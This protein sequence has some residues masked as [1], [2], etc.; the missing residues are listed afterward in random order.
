MQHPIRH[1]VMP[2]EVMLVRLQEQLFQN[3]RLKRILRHRCHRQQVQRVTP[4]CNPIS[5]NPPVIQAWCFYPSRPRFLINFPASERCSVALGPG[6]AAASCTSR[7]PTAAW[8]M[9]PPAFCFPTV[10]LSP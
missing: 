10:A 6:A 3:L 1:I 4:R 8:L 9:P 7:R 5:R 2:L